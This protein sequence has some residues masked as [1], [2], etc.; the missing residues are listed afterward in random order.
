MA[1]TQSPGSI[2]AE[3][4]NFTSVSSPLGFSISWISAL[5]VSGSVPMT[6]AS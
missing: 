4:P 3:S 2:C 5:S 6:L 1:I